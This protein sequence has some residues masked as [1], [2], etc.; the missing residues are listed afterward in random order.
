MLT[1]VL[2]AE[3]LRVPVEDRKCAVPHVEAG[4]RI[5]ESNLMEHEA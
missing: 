3:T 2:P 1:K 5:M 4:W